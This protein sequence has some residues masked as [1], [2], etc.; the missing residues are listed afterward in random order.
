MSKKS[1]RQR[2]PNL[3]PEAFNM[4][5]A[6]IAGAAPRTAEAAADATAQRKLVDINWKKEYSE[7][8]GDLR[9]TAI[10]AVIMM[11][12]MGVLSFIIH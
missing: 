8:L 2:R 7:V 3:P 12:A 11:V 9:R 1:R 5:S 10:L 6:S 4:P